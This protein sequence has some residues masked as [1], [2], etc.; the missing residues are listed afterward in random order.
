M[1]F[2]NAPGG[3]ETIGAANHAAIEKLRMISWKFCRGWPNIAA[4]ASPGKI[5]Q[6]RVFDI[7]LDSGVAIETSGDWLLVVTGADR[8]FAL[9]V[10]CACD[11][12]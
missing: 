9:P 4:S 7:G 11:G 6:P 2:S 8:A 5:R 1:S 12:G 3:S 10:R